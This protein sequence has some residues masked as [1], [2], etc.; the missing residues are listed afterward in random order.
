MGYFSNAFKALRYVS[1]RFQPEHLELVQETNQLLRA[2]WLLQFANGL[3]FDLTNTLAGHFKDVADFFK[4]I[5]ITVTQ[6]VTQLKI[7][8]SR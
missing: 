2:T 6:T 8:R 1:I 3:G 4:R 5:A 7:S